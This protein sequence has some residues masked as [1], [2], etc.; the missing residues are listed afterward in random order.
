MS[1]KS[2]FEVYYFRQNNFVNVHTSHAYLT[3]HVK[4]FLGEEEEEVFHNSPL[5]T[6]WHQRWMPLEIHFD[7]C[8]YV[9]LLN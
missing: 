5:F 9:F 7:G 4:C 2:T 1:L 6:S 3:V 8:A